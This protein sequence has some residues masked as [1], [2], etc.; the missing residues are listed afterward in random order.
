MF[1]FGDYQGTRTN[2]GIDTGLIAVPTLADRTG[3]LSGSGQSL[4]GTVSGP[5][6]AN[7]LSQKLGYRVAAERTLLHAGL[8]HEF[9]SACSRTPS[10][11]SAPG[12]RRHSI[13][14]STFRCPTPERRL[15]RPASEGQTTRDDKGS[16]RVDGNSNRLGTLSAYYFFDDYTVNNPYPTG[17]G[18]A[19]VPGLQCTESG[20]RATRQCRRTRRPSALPPS[21]NFA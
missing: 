12:R 14:C 15:F 13:C 3:N 1:F 4:T 11:R 10:S 2:Q 16:F 5:Y 8:R 18:G 6:L 19:S 17:Q 9:A 20:P 7:L 21:T